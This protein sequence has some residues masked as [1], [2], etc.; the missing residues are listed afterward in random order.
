L[1]LNNRDFTCFDGVNVICDEPNTR[2]GGSSVRDKIDVG[3][4]EGDNSGDAS[5]V[6]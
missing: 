4:G 5:G 3:E 1:G 6:K 2:K